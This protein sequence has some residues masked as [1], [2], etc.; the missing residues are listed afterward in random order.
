MKNKKARQ[1]RKRKS[2]PEPWPAELLLPDLATLNS[3]SLPDGG[4]IVQAELF[5]EQAQAIFSRRSI[6]HAYLP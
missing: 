1:S 4:P 3:L 5:P 6:C 2:K